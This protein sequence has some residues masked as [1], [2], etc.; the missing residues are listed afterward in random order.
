M[1]HNEEVRTVRSLSVSATREKPADPTEPN[2]NER[3]HTSGEFLSHGT[4]SIRLT[5]GTELCAVIGHGNQPTYLAGHG[6]CRRGLG[7]GN[8]G[9]GG[10]AGKGLAFVQVEEDDSAM[11]PW[12][13]TVTLALA[14]T[15]T[16]PG[17]HV[18]HSV[19]GE[20]QACPHHPR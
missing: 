8:V 13:L 3:D 9:P 20:D 18:P 16:C 12:M 6:S 11:V 7:V 5:V 1:L 15:D 2:K 4:G 17:A 19:A 14:D 10:Y